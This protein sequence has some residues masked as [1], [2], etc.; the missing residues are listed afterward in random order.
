MD[1]PD[2]RFVMLSGYKEEELDTM[3]AEHEAVVDILRKPVQTAVLEAALAKALK[4]K[5]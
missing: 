1:Q 2:L 5:S 4:D 3:I